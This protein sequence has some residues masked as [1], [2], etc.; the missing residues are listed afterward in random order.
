MTGIAKPPLLG[1]REIESI[2]SQR[3]AKDRF[4]RLKDLP[5]PEKLHGI[6]QACDLIIE[7]MQQKRRIVV[8]GDYDVDGIVSTAIWLIF[9]I[10][11]PIPSLLLFPIDFVM[12]MGSLL[13]S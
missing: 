13:R 11:S 8:I 1:K 12:V 5:P 9:F 3:F 6:P 7:S 10:A 4:C 2:L